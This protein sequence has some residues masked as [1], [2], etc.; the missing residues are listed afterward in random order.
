MTKFSPKKIFIFS[1][2]RLR[3]GAAVFS[4]FLGNIPD[5]AVSITGLGGWWGGRLLVKKVPLFKYGVL[6][7]QRIS[8]FFLSFY[9]SSPEAL[10]SRL[11]A[12]VCLPER[13][14]K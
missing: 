4:I 13:K 2:A 9:K 12:R 11:A 14:E 1:L 8:F 7:F 3:E 10:T 5:Q 6:C